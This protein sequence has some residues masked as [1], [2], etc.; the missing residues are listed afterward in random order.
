MRKRTL[1]AFTTYIW[2]KTLLGLT[3]TP[4][5]SVREV[6]RRPVLFPVIFS[7]FLGIILLLIFGR[8][9]ALFIATEGMERIVIAMILSSAVISIFLWQILLVYLL[10]TYLFALW[11]NTSKN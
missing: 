2:T 4:F 6:I 9:A 7:P 8:I 10:L 3:F 5:V 11:K 1:F